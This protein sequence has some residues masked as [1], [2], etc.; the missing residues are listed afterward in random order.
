MAHTTKQCSYYLKPSKSAVVDMYDSTY[1]APA[2]SGPQPRLGLVTMTKRPLDLDHWLAYHFHV[3][4]VRKFFIQVED[5]PEVAALLLAPPWNE[6]VDV[7]F[8]SKTARDYFVQMDRQAVHVAASLPRAKAADIDWLIHVDDDELLFCPHGAPAFWATLALA[9]AHVHDVHVANLEALA[10]G[11]CAH[12]FATCTRFIAATSRFTS[13]TNGKSIGRVA[14]PGLRA[15]GPHHF[16]SSAPG[17]A[18]TLNLDAACC[19][20]LHYE[21][22]TFERWRRKFGDLAKQHGG[23]AAVLEKLPFPFYRDSLHCL[24]RCMHAD[25]AARPAADAAAFTCWEAR[26]GEAATRIAPAEL[27]D[28]FAVRDALATLCPPPAGGDGAPAPAPQERAI[29]APA[30]LLKVPKL[31]IS[32]PASPGAVG[33]AAAVELFVVGT[34]RPRDVAALRSSR[35]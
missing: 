12:P 31:T 20:V 24:W 3:V 30:D 34:P 26:K 22:C 23:D 11:G 35:Q 33:A 19:V 8:V 5:S 10:P 32:P 21:S 2:F 29:L 15:H 6:F 13:Y 1:V 16:R 27:A 28:V 7:T 18:Q 25:A 14:A 4:G 17:N 9:P